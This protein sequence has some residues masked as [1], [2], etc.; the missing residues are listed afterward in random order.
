MDLSLF[1]YA[2]PKELVA[3][4]PIRPRD[5]SRL[6][7]HDRT[8]GRTEH[9]H[10]RDLPNYLYPGDLLIFNDTK[11]FRARLKGRRDKTGGA[12]ELLLLRKQADNTWEALVTP[13]RRLKPG[14][15]VVFEGSDLRVEILERTSPGGRTIRFEGSADVMGELQRIG[16]VPT[17]PY[18]E[19]VVTEEEEYQTVY[20]ANVGAAA[21]PTAGFHFSSEL[22]DRLKGQGVETAFVTLHIGIDTFRPMVARRIED[23]VMHSECFH[24]PHATVEAVARA[25]RKGRRVVAVGTTTVR[26]LESAACSGDLQP[27]SG[28]TKLYI[29]PGYAFRVVDALITNFHLPKSTLLVMVSA[30]AGREQILG[31]Y[32]EA[33]QRRYRLFSFG[34]AMLIL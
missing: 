28:W 32:Q 12:A 5:S 26:T 1:D 21:A 33:I 29:R 20:A 31:L 6:L 27:A 24:V 9:S 16:E 34:D 15:R 30:F 3:Q 4:R 17:P 23:H 18:I 10:F 25:H 8:S 7:V 22:L 13:G 19:R 11:V 14:S 2:F